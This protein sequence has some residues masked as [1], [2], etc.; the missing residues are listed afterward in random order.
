VRNLFSGWANKFV[1]LGHRQYALVQKITPH[2]EEKLQVLGSV[3]K[4]GARLQFADEPVGLHQLA[5]IDEIKNIPIMN[6][7]DA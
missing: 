4:N 6:V 5:E 3:K 7:L 1:T 2:G